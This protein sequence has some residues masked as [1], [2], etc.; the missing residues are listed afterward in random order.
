MS[1]TII[2]S[3]AQQLSVSNN[4]EPRQLSFTAAASSKLYVAENDQHIVAVLGR[5]RP[6]DQDYLT[7]NSAEWFLALYQRQPECFLSQIAGFFLVLILDKRSGIIQVIN[8]HVGSIPCYIDQRDAG[9]ICISDN[10]PALTQ[11]TANTLNPQALFNYVFYHCIPSPIS[12]YQGISKLE[13]GVVASLAANGQ[14]SQHNYYQPAFSPSADSTEQ[15]MQRCRE[16]ISEAVRRNMA[17]DCAAFL[18]G[19]L[20][21]STVAGMLAKH[22]HSSGQTAKT[23]SIGF[24]AKGYDETEYAL[25]TAKHFAT[26][27]KVHYLQPDEIANHFTEVAGYFNEPFGNSSAMAAYICAKTA[28]ADGI[29]VLL[30]GDGGDEIFAG[31][32]RYV[33]QKVFQRFGALPGPLQA[34]LSLGLDNGLADKLPLVKKASSYVRQAKVPLPDRLDSYNF[35]NRFNLQQMFS[36][37]LLQRVD[38]AQPAEQKR[39][40]YNACQSSDAVDSMMYL[41]WKFT[42]ADNDFV[43]VQ[44][45][46]HLAGVEVRFPLIEKELVDFSCTVPATLKA[47]GQL[48]RD[49]Y[50]NSFRGFLP[51]ATLSKSKHG[52]GLP[53]GVWMKQRPDLQHIALNALQSFKQ[54]NILQPAFIDQAID[55]FENGHSGYYG[56]LVWIIVVLELWLQQHGASHV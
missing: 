48:L 31:N 27:N 41:D 24:E 32:E 18:S 1:W 7:S 12:I 3:S 2:N 23:Y 37:E 15:L 21:S 8:D 33:K 14:L 46:C 30:A 19:G 20:D 22:S 35:V 44:Q 45:M 10:M 43:K 5:L 17:D 26:A 38:T 47:P 28:K 52:F 39:V 13:P 16:L 4:A 42:L 29:Q 50:K 11:A 53:F 51:D 34:L 40:R 36:P 25:I 54:R 9:T 56:E 6:Y 55:T 49:F